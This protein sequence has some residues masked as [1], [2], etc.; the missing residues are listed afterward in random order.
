MSATITPV[1]VQ[2][3]RK[4]GFKLSNAAGNGLNTVY[5]GRGSLWGNKYKVGDNHPDHGWP[6]NHCE[7]V[8]LFKEYVRFGK[9]DEESR[10]IHFEIKQHLGGKNLACWCPADKPCHVDILLE[11]A[12]P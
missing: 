7:V 12:N 3:S 2:R 6:M 9:T 8:T 11:I 10:K 5:V 1:R 4:K